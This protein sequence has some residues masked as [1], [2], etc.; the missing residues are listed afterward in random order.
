[1]EYIYPYIDGPIAQSVANLP[2]N[3]GDAGSNPGR[4]EAACAHDYSGNPGQN[5]SLTP[6]ILSTA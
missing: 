3:P 5:L 4:R 2:A 6:S 1:M